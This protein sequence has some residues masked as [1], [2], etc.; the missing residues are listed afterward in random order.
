[1]R[2]TGISESY[3]GLS[4]PRIIERAGEAVDAGGEGSVFDAVPEYRTKRIEQGMADKNLR[5]NNG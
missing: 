1:L 3:G 5:G 2:L 4:L